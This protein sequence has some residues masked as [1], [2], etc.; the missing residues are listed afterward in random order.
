MY[1]Y[2]YIYVYIYPSYSQLADLC[3]FRVQYNRAVFSSAYQYYCHLRGDV[4]IR[5]SHN[6]QHT[7]YFILDRKTYCI[8]P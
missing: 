3:N 5:F 4:N 6:L 1:I 7:Y 2:M 8:I